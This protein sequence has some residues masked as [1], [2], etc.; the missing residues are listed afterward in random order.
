MLNRFNIYLI[1]GLL[2]LVA[3]KK[4]TVVLPGSVAGNSRVSDAALEQYIFRSYI[5]LL[6]AAPSEEELMDWSAGLRADDLSESARIAM[7]ETLQTGTNRQRYIGNLYA[8]AKERFLENIDDAEINR[9]FI[10]QGTADD[11]A[12]LQG[13]L[14]WPAQYLAGNADIINLQQSCVYNLV[15]DQI[16]MGSFNMVRASFDNLLWRYPTDAEFDAGYSM[17]ERQQ[18][19]QL[20]GFSGSS[21]SE[22]VDIICNSEEALQGIVIWQYD[23]LLARRPTAAETLSHLPDLRASSSIELMQQAIMKTDEYAGF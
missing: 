1:I 5:D 2:S 18:T 21:K 6:G 4:E 12:R 23:Q 17:I 10:G 15:Y 11:D 8:A 3:C 14:A 19:G 16:N 13:L 9:R 7:V 22:Y 20:W